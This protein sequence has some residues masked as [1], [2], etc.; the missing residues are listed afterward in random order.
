MD[1]VIYYLEMINAARIEMKSPEEGRHDRL[2]TWN[3]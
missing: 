1:A 2:R 3:G